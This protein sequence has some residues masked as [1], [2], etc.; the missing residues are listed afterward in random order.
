MV[1]F[2][3]TE[4]ETE[5]LL[6]CFEGQLSMPFLFFIVMHLFY[7]LHVFFLLHYLEVGR[8]SVLYI[9]LHK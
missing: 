1:S 6:Q 8:F 2:F 9:C 4:N 5:I 7:L 3:D